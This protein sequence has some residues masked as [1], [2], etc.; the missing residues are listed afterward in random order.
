MVELLSDEEI[1]KLSF[2]ESYKK[3]EQ[4]VSKLEDNTEELERSIEYYD[5]GMKLKN[6]CDEKLKLAE[7]KIKKVTEDNKSESL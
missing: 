3:L 6:H 5:L 2:E 7:L 1:K 4:I